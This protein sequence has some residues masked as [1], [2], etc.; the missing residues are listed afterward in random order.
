MPSDTLVS[1]RQLLSGWGR[2]TAT[3]SLVAHP[4]TSPEVLRI[5]ARGTARG[6][7]A[8]G[9]GRSYGDSALSAGGT[10]VDMTRLGR[11]LHV[12]PDAGEVRVEAGASFDLLARILL[13]RGW[14]LPVTP[15]TRSVTVGGAIAADVHG[16]NHHR[17]GSLGR[18]V[19]SML[20]AL[21]DGTAREVSPT[22]DPDLFWA[23]VG[24]MG[25]TGVVLEATLRLLPV[26]SAWMTVTTE[27]AGDLD[28]VLA[29]L[30]DADRRPYSVAWVDL[31]ATGPR[32]GRGVV[33]SA[34][35]AAVE[36]LPSR[37]RRRAG[38]LGRPS[39]LQVPGWC[40]PGLLNPMS[41][42]AFNE[43]WYRRSPSRTDAIESIGGYFHPLDGVRGWNRL[44]GPH[45]LV[46]HQ[47]VVPDERALRDVVDRIRVSRVPSFL[48]VLKRFG[49]DDPAPL[50]FPRPGWTLAFDVPA[51]S[52]GLTDLLDELDD[53]VVAAGGSVYLAKDA[54][55]R[56]EHLAAC[57]PRLD[58]WR[59]V[60][61][62][63]DPKRAFV[64]DQA[65]RLGL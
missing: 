15:G 12:D 64:S 41:I 32:A 31:M 10:V 39:R 26:P 52:S 50:S 25:L 21:A 5:L 23:T 4:R 22:D 51:A 16:K 47:C 45:G 54:R 13:P 3:S 43:A 37:A 53:V 59:E 44:Y 49:A 30:Q 58:E 55:M 40:P 63:V 60:R 20:L 36:D 34:E 11:V 14:F 17:A 6:M 1:E 2:T 8:R 28:G 19:R 24:G 46:Q 18:H 33:T 7:I 56:P 48:A 38:E 62:R 42:T 57:Y 29:A 61:E 65:R 35:H 27:R 9:L